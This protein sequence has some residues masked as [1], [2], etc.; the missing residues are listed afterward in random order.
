MKQCPLCETSNPD[1]VAECDECGYN[2][3][4]EEVGDQIRKY[5]EYRKGLPWVEHI[6]KRKRVYDFLG[7]SVRNLAERLQLALGTL[8][9]DL[10]LARGLEE[11]PELR[12]CK[13]K[14]HALKLLAVYEGSDEPPFKSELELQEYLHDH[15][16]DT[17]LVEEW[18]P[19]R[20]GWSKGKQKI[21]DAGEMDL[22]AHHRK[23]PRWLVIEL[24][25]VRTSDVAVG[26]ILRYMGWVK[27]HVA[28]ENEEVQGLI[29]SPSIDPHVDYA[30]KFTRN[31]QCRLY[32][33]KDNK[34]QL[35]DEYTLEL[36]RRIKAGEISKEKIERLM[37]AFEEAPSN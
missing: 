21:G 16:K 15:W 28:N 36:I 1:D 17:S 27:D 2:F 3:E 29:I 4:T 5:V 10:K 18:D 12:Q 32:R 33:W 11:H 23:E 14:N 31:I 19:P 8:S 30:L 35:W 24:K 7:C 9:Q 34:L 20:Q 37:Q 22:L 6:E 26:Q 25:I 13:N